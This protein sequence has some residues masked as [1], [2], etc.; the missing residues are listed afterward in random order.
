MEINL[1]QKKR[2]LKCQIPE[3]KQTL[4]ILKTCG[5]KRVHQFTGDQILTG[6]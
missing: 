4:E 5:R 1:A 3:I 6:R 2:G